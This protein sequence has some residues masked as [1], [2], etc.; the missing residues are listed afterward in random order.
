MMGKRR[1]PVPQ[2]AIL[3]VILLF[4][5]SVGAMNSSTTG[6]SNGN[7]TPS[8]ERIAEFDSDNFSDP[9]EIDNEWSPL[10][11]GTQ[12]ILEGVAD[13]LPHRVVFT[14]T[15]LVKEID[16]VPT[17]VL[18]DVDYSDGVIKEAE[19][20][21]KAQDDDGNVWNLGEYPKEYE[22]G[23]FLGAPN[24]WIAGLAE[25][26]AGLLM[27]AES[28]VG[29]GYYLQGSVPTIDFLDC[30]KVYKTGQDSCV[31]LTCYEDVVIIDERSPLD[32]REGHQRKFYAPGVG[33]FEIGATGRSSG[34]VLE[35]VSI[36]QLSPAGLA[37]AREE[38]LKLEERAYEISDVYG[39]TSPAQ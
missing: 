22:D 26:E 4:M 2:L 20:A 28:Q 9:T 16:G 37:N 31:P 36:V 13:D 21:F 24:T 25:A 19:L 12:M 34:E 14:V 29:T 38:A 3:T 17:I 5:A 35:L 10:V 6:A 11:P 7:D 30:A 15:D 18:W 33:N 23:E 32:A 8:C 39:D 27:Q 1:V